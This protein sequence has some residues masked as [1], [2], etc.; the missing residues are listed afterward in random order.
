MLFTQ[1]GRVGRVCGFLLILCQCCF[2]WNESVLGG[3]ECPLCSTHLS[4][5]VPA[6]SPA[7]WQCLAHSGCQSMVVK[8]L[9]DRLN[10]WI[11]V[12][13]R[14]FIKCDPALLSMVG[15]ITDIFPL[16]SQYYTGTR[17]KWGQ[18]GIVTRFC[19]C[20]HV[21]KVQHCEETVIWPWSWRKGWERQVHGE[22]KW[23][24]ESQLRAYQPWFA[25]PTEAEPHPCAGLQEMIQVLF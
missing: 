19:G 7:P 6:I 22:E 25:E 24:A 21:S 16:S 12:L 15:C 10:E 4:A 1:P 14:Y 11:V 3:Q 17:W 23:E 5:A 9:T 13:W 8:W 20:T 18:T 2:S